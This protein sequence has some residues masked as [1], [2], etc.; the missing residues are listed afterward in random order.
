MGRAPRLPHQ[1]WAEA[2]AMYKQQPDAYRLS[3]DE[4]KLRAAINDEYMIQ[5][6]A[7][8]MLLK[9]YGIDPAL[10]TWTPAM[11][12]VTRLEALGLKGNQYQHLKDLANWKVY[13]EEPAHTKYKDIDVYKLTSWTQGPVLL[14][15][16]NIL[17]HL[18]LKSMGYNSSRYIHTLY[19]SMNLAFAD[20]DFYYGDPYFPPVEPMK[21]LLSKKYAKHRLKEINWD[22][23][24]PAVAPGDPYK[25]QQGKNPYKKYLKDKNFI[26]TSFVPKGKLEQTLDGVAEA[27]LLE[28]R[29]P[30]P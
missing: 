29:R 25:F 18:D 21:G 20:R 24:D 22:R 15:T 12:I 14:Q 8:Q 4:V 5:I 10:D 23:N 27:I 13:I 17:G 2:V 16:L 9:H 6:P 19:Q 11:D 1:V 26:A 28:V 7:V 30:L 3:P